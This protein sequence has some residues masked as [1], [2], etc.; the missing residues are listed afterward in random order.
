V[1]GEPKIWCDYKT[2]SKPVACTVRLALSFVEETKRNHEASNTLVG[3]I[4]VH[5]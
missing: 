5:G 2:S 4:G 3:A 1:T